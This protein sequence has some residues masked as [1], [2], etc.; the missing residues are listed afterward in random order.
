ME[1][2]HDVRDVPETYGLLTTRELEITGFLNDATK[3][4]TEIFFEE[5]IARAKELDREQSSSPD[6]L[7]GPFQRPPI[8]PKDSFRSP[9]YDSTTGIVCWAFQPDDDYSAL[10]KLWLDRG[11]VLYRKTNV[12]QTMMTADSDNN[13]GRTPN[14]ANSRLTAGGSSGGEGALIGLRGCVWGMGTDIAGSIRIP[15][16][17]DGIFGFRPSG[18]VVPY[19]GQKSPA[20]PGMPGSAPVAGPIATSIRAC[21][22]FKKTIMEAQPWK[23]D[24]TC[25]HLNWNSYDA[26]RILG[27]GDVTDDGEYAVVP[28]E[29]NDERDRGK[30]AEGWRGNLSLASSSCIFLVLEKQ[31]RQHSGSMR[32][33]AAG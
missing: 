27:I 3:C 1:D 28:C 8:S 25:L 15:S 26:I 13:L 24:P 30:A 19:G 22:D 5:A 20:K 10:P 16:I 21:E 9:G 29:K 12:P 31:L 17:A 32:W 6:R 18:S 2:Q 33:M 23:Y 4:L 7:L 11:A 14:P